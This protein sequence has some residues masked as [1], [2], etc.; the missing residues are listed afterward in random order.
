[1]LPISA[2]AE[3]A[4]SW[5]PVGRRIQL[6]HR[7]RPVWV[8]NLDQFALFVPFCVALQWWRD[9]GLYHLIWNCAPPRLCVTPL[10]KV[11]VD[12]VEPLQRQ[13]TNRSAD[14]C[15]LRRFSSACAVTVWPESSPVT[16]W[17]VKNATFLHVNVKYWPD[18]WCG[19]DLS[20]LW[21][22]RSHVAAQIQWTLVISTWLISNN[23]LSR[24]ENI[25]PA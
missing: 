17:M 9:I 22:Q 8:I 19:D 24:S 1:M 2:G 15:P 3:P 25:V 18:C 6:S 7:G 21:A 20:L 14:I 23:S 5:S 4:I 12:M 11:T 16:V 10:S 13:K